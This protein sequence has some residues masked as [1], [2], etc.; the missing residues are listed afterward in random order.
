MTNERFELLLQR[1]IKLIIEVLSKKSK[2]YAIDDNRLH[3]FFMASRRRNIT[4]AQALD[5]MMLKHEVSIDDMI[6]N[7]VQVT[8]ELVDEKIGDMINYLI[9]LEAIFVNELGMK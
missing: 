7:R 1:R 3:N 2:E 8:R 6:N 5:G 9:L 4:P